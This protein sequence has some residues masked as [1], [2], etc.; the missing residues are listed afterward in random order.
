MRKSINRAT[1]S[2]GKATP[3]EDGLPMGVARIFKSGN[4][5]THYDIAREQWLR[6][7]LEASGRFKT[8]D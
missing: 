2:I 1:E 6:E 3:I 5:L 7:K 8:P 4:V